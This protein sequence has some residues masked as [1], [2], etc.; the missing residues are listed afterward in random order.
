MSSAE[1]QL[2]TVTP[3]PGFARMLPSEEQVNASIA[4][5]L[6]EFD[7]IIEDATSG[8]E[9]AFDGGMHFDR[10]YRFSDGSR[11]TTRVT[12]P[13]KQLYDRPLSSRLPWCTD[14][15]GLYGEYVDPL[16]ARN[17]S[18]SVRTSSQRRSLLR[19]A[20][21]AI[22][23]AFSESHLLSHYAYAHH[24]ILNELEEQGIADFSEVI[25]SGDSQAG[26]TNLAFQG[27]CAQFGRSAPYNDI[28]DICR[29]DKVT[30]TLDPRVIAATMK[31]LLLDEPA[32]LVSSAKKYSPEE[33][34]IL[35]RTAPADVRFWLHQLAV[36]HDLFSGVTG[37]FVDHVPGNSTTA[38][39]FFNGSRLNHAESFTARLSRLPGVHI[40][41]EDGTHMSIADPD[42]QQTTIDRIDLAQE[43]LSGGVLPHE[44]D[45]AL[46]VER[47]GP[48]RPSALSGRLGRAAR[49]LAQTAN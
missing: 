16:H 36:G 43:L 49:Q 32:E 10:H 21:G 20:T 18:L 12:Q 2:A 38:L 28:T 13:H 45:A 22:T 48:S 1:N 14:L 27:L 25:E 19:A 46:I 34:R 39:R 37:G 3:L 15:N 7:I 29:A 6:P 33:R 5:P 17:G 47:V 40:Y 8:P 41:H 30:P 44:L 23:G 4:R 31:Y 35:A 24:V 26:M 9:I 42:V 11:Y